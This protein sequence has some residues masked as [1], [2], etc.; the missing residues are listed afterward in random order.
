M[1]LRKVKHAA[2]TLQAND[3]LIIQQPTDYKGKWNT[4]FDNHHPIEIEIGTGKGK[5]IIEL[6]KKHPEKNFIGIEKYDSVLIRALEKASLENLPNLR[7]VWMD[8]ETITETFELGEVSK[9]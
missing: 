5:F 7:L 8:A 9:I 2:A 3:Q 4:V 1:R 6:A